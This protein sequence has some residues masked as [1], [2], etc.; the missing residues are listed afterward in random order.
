[1]ICDSFQWLIQTCV[2]ILKG[3]GSLLWTEKKRL[4]LKLS[5][6]N[7]KL[8]LRLPFSDYKESKVAEQIA[9]DCCEF[10]ITATVNS[11]LDKYVRNHLSRAYI[12]I[13]EKDRTDDLSTSFNTSYDCALNLDMQMTYT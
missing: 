1:M 5:W 11:K 3:V 2:Q 8:N 4:N 6:F 12:V 13:K 9:W 7:L 10:H